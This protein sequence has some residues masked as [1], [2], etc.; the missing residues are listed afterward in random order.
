MI[1]EI[2]TDGAAI[3]NPG[4]GGWATVVIEKDKSTVHYGSER[5]TTN[6]RMEMQAVIKAFE[7]AEPDDNFVIYSDSEYVVKG[8]MAWMFK[9]RNKGWVKVKNPDLWRK[10]YQLR[11]EKKFI[12]VQWVRGHNGLKYNEVADYYA[13]MALNERKTGNVVFEYFPQNN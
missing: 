2:F 1:Q 12:T 11:I 5:D 9:W 6:N 10:L 8:A 7:L 13:G 4:M 3:P